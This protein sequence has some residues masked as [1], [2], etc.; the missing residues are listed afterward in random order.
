MDLI[1]TIMKI[2]RADCDR[3]SPSH[4]TRGIILG[5]KYKAP[6]LK[7]VTCE[8]RLPKTKGWDSTIPGLMFNKLQSSFPDRLPIR[9]LETGTASVGGGIQHQI[10][11]ME[12]SRFSGRE[13]RANTHVDIAP[14]YIA[15]H[16][17]ETYS[18]WESFLP[19]IEDVLG[20]FHEAASP[21]FSEGI[22]AFSRVGL[23]YINRVK[24]E[25]PSWKPD[26]YFDLYPHVGDSLPGEFVTFAI[27]IQTRLKNGRDI[28]QTQMA[29]IP[30]DKTV[31][32]DF[33]YFLGQ[34]G[35]VGISESLSWI[36]EAHDVIEAA[37]EGTI[38]DPL[39]ELFG[40]E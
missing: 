9:A 25:D 27:V 35:E 5:R 17:T 10:S 38:K 11:V 8:F 6:P 23:R 14:F 20:A 24:I 18:G 3:I 16:Q 37:F 21:L 30:D 36:R 33:D 31:V 32:L 1:L 28:L 12:R 15:I 39:R 7:A 13:S 22:P 34:P 26:K 19:A 4:F 29:T 2:L 40:G